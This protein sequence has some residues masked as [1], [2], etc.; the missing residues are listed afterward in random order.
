MC[1]LLI[2]ACAERRERPPPSPARHALA[3]LAP[4]GPVL[5]VV[6]GQPFGVDEATRDAIVTA[7]LARGIS[8]LEASFTTD[9]AR[10]VTTDPRLVVVLGPVGDPPATLACTDPDRIATAPAG[11]ELAV[12]AVFC[13]GD[14]PLGVARQRSPASG[15]DT[16]EARRLLWRTGAQLFPD[17]YW[18]TYGVDLIPGIDLGIGGT[19]GF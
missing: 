18:Q 17:D 8:G 14:E 7:E 6:R 4:S 12:L 11:R 1:C 19:F 9:P 10:A 13:R 15:L 16:R 2:A 5:A 3:E